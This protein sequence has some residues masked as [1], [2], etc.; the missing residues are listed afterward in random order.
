MKLCMTARFLEKK[1]CQKMHQKWTKNRVF[2]FNEK[3]GHYILLKLFYNENWYLMCSCTNPID[4]E[5]ILLLRY[6]PNCS[7]PIRLENFEINYIPRA[8]WFIYFFIIIIFFIFIYSWLELLHFVIILSLYITMEN[9]VLHWKWK[10][11]WRQ[12]NCND[13]YIYIYIYMWFLLP[14]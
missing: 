8:S 13:I 2:E 3:F 10:A 5:K 6:G 12:L 11:N 7:Q 14:K 1:S 4:Q 9:S